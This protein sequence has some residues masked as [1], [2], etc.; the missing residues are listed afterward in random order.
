ME[1]KIDLIQEELISS[2]KVWFITGVAGFI[3]SNLLE[4]LLKLNQRVYGL[5]NFITGKLSNL[6]DVKSSVSKEQWTNFKFTKG[7]I[8]DF[9]LCQSM[10]FGVDYV[11][12]HAAL[13]SVP[14]SIK[15]PIAT[16][17][18]NVSGFLNILVASRDAEV[19]RFIY[20]TS[21]SVYGDYP[22]LPKIE[23]KLG[24]LLS[25]YALTKSVNELYAK[26]FTKLYSF[27]TIGLRYFNVFGKRQDSKGEYAAVIPKWICAML[28]DEQ[29]CINGDGQTSRDF[30][31]IDNVVDANLLAATAN[32]VVNEDN[33]YN[34]AYG[35]N[36]ALND[37]FHF[38][39]NKISEINPG[40][41]IVPPIYLDFR[42]GDIK[43][44]LAS[45]QKAKQ[46]LNYD[47]QFSVFEGLNKTLDWFCKAS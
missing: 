22:G 19:S 16:N 40:S 28:N 36:I 2:P 10:C 14:R 47:P 30:C 26:L 23:D 21:S 27:E 44:S 5:D 20:A 32:H 46:F 15:N 18:N 8:N 31:F 4:R 24:D 37:L 11:L 45:I 41:K 17:L 6:E 35:E 38:L 34:I 39:K 42:D 29:I 43:H 7:D 13:G 1:K 33:I 12:H 3:G 25:P 9:K